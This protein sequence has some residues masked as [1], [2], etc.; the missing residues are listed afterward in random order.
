VVHEVP[1]LSP[2]K[3]AEHLTAYAGRPMIAAARDDAPLA[4]FLY[5]NARGGWIL[6]RSGDRLTRRRFS[7]AHELGHYV[8]HFLPLLT[9]WSA[10]G[11]SHSTEDGPGDGAGPEF[12]EALPPAAD[13]ELVE[14]GQISVGSLVDAPAVDGTGGADLEEEVDRFAAELLMPAWR[15]RSLVERHRHAYA[16]RRP[17]LARRLATEFL[18]SR[19]A[20]E[21]RLTELGLGQAT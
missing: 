3:A 2:R 12:E 10:A 11:P 19:Q 16:D 14:R 1:D 5:A 6:V 20:M 4:G 13:E 17:V 21:R 15:C 9:R 18:V 8:L 7:V